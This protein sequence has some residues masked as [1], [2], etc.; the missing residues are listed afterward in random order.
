M[1]DRDLR[2]LAITGAR[3][4]EFALESLRDVEIQRTA[5]GDA[6]VAVVVKIPAEY[7][8]PNGRTLAS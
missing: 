4:G 3:S 7:L 6:Y 1:N 5:S 2:A 8:K